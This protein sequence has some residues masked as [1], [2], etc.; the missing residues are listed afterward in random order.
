MKRISYLLL[1]LAM[2]VFCA[3]GNELEGLQEEK[4]PSNKSEIESAEMF[5]F[6]S[7]KEFQDAVAQLE[8]MTAG[9][10][11]GWVKT[12]FGSIKTLQDV[13]FE[14]LKEAA[15]LDETE[16]SYKAY[17][18]KYDKYLY[19]A[20]F[21]EDC[22]VYLPVSNKAMAA[23]LNIDGNVRIAGEVKNMKD[24]DSYIKLQENG[25]AMYNGFDMPTRAS[26]GAYWQPG[27][28]DHSNTFGAESSGNIGK[29]YDSSWWQ[30]SSRRVRL[31][32]GRKG[33]TVSDMTNYFWGRRMR[34]HI[35]VSFRKKT[36]LGWS[37]YSSE[38]QTTGTFTGGYNNSIDF[39]HSGD[40]SHDWYQDL[41]YTSN[42]VNGTIILNNPAINADLEIWFRGLGHKLNVSFTLPAITATA[43]NPT[44]L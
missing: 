20:S 36:W 16:A 44:I 32:C 29:E 24:V 43:G 8:Q 22:G 28:I 35:E 18:E 27:F 2:S 12:N 7:E 23:L 31:K 1:V 6:N 15:Y 25:E 34:L 11:Q 13:Y 37:N 14:A 42:V 30:E 39:Y 3:C 5:S 21:L 17:K 33:D 26:Y 9:E 10:Q 19:F 41:I 38:T 40:S 4:S